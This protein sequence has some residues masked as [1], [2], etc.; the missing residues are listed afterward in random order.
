MAERFGE[1][2]HENRF[3]V[4]SNSSCIPVRRRVSHLLS[5]YCL[6][7]IV[8]Y[9][10]Q[11]SRATEHNTGYNGWTERS[12]VLAEMRCRHSHTHNKHEH[13]YLCGMQ[14][15]IQHTHKDVQYYTHT[16]IHWNKYTSA[17]R[18]KAGTATGPE[19]YTSS[20]GVGG[21]T[22]TLHIHTNTHRT[23]RHTHKKTR[24]CIPKAES[25]ETETG[26]SQRITWKTD[27]REGMTK[28]YVD[29]GG[30]R[31]HLH[32]ERA[33]WWDGVLPVCFCS[34][35]NVRKKTMV[36]SELYHER[37]ESCTLTARVWLSCLIGKGKDKTSCAK[38]FLGPTCVWCLRQWQNNCLSLGRNIINIGNYKG[39][40]A[41]TVSYYRP[42]TLCIKMF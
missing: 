33:A 32:W 10:S 14:M 4:H 22:H 34:S 8:L 5:N 16:H 31:Y 23:Q 15:N 36:S 17:Q 6:F 35:D 12:W 37:L 19:V 25:G 21:Y 20:Y 42:R 29:V 39:L 30:E 28:N 26:H 2:V 11:M 3:D 1:M 18:H 41:S 27:T 40:H 13:T 38:A 7:C 9:R 24:A